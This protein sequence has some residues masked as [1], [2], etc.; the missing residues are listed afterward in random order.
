AKSPIYGGLYRR[1]F[2][3][4]VTT[5]DPKDIGDT[6][7]HEVAR[8]I[9]DGLVEF[10]SDTKV[11]PA[12]AKSWELS[13]D[14]LT[15]TFKLLAN[16]RF[17]ASSGA[18][19]QP[20]RNGG[21]LLS[22]EDV[23][24]TFHRLLNPKSKVQRNRNFWVIN[25]AKSFNEG[26][27]KRIEGIKILASDSISFTLEKPFA[28]FLSLLA[29]SNAFI[30]PFEDA[31]SLGESFGVSPVGTGAFIWGGKV[32]ETIILKSNLNYFRG[33]PYLDQIEFPVIKDEKERFSAFILGELQHTDVPNSEFM[34]IKQDPK[35]Y[36]LFQ[37]S[38]RWGTHYLGFNV[39]LPPFD[40]P[41]VRIA[42]NY[43]VDREG[44]VKLILN[45]RAKVARGVIPPGIVAYNPNLQ[46]YAYDVAK[47]RKYLADAG[48]PEGK[49]F[50]EIFLQTNKD[51]FHTRIGE[52][53]LANLRD[54]GIKCSI[55]EMDFQEHLTSVESGLA[56]FFRMGWT[57]DYPD[58][59]DLLF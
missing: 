6:F 19:N 39:T 59:D 22:A 32:G 27:S 21:R 57:V 30:V 54:I 28:P 5:L 47:G 36:P 16:C 13:S 35:W 51:A 23:S 24:Y 2:N 9:F 3:S 42:F 18:Q 33:R 11:V 41:K 29:L 1:A 49:G 4:S 48:Y 58:P 43:A 12:L 44:I 40:N 20:T 45:D 34:N 31:E 53:V 8:Q 55:R 15:Y 50:P 14:R 37:E 56:P 26:F 7:S 46:S 17:H 25:G 38:S 52:F 10:D